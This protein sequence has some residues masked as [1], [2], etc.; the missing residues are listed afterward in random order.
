MQQLLWHLLLSHLLSHA[1]TTALTA[2]T[3]Y[4]TTVVPPLLVRPSL[5][6]GHK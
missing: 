6:V 4:Y 3:V 2:K 5:P 1:M